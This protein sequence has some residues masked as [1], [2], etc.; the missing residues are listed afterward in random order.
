MPGRPDPQRGQMLRQWEEA[1]GSPPPPYLSVS[2]MQKAVAYQ[3]Q[4]RRHGGLPAASRKALRRIAE[5][6]AVAEASPSN[7]RT[8]TTLV[9][10]WNGRSYQV[11]V[12]KDGFRMDGKTWRSLSAIARHITGATW[13][14]PRFFGVTDRAGSRP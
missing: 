12:V 1:F 10:E 2:F 6:D 11:E 4:C 9:R 5:G 13:S 8:G 3:E 7:Q 14:G